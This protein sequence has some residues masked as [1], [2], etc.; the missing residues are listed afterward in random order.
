MA[1]PSSYTTGCDTIPVRGGEGPS[2]EV[3][4]HGLPSQDHRR[5][6]PSSPSIAG[7]K[8]FPAAFVD[9]WNSW[10][11]HPPRKVIL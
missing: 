3:T 8:V 7:T 2:V 6:F 5:G 4:R 1:K 9:V 11:A 10:W